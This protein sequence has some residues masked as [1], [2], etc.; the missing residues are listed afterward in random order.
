MASDGCIVLWGWE[1][2]GRK[3]GSRRKV[4]TIGLPKSNSRGEI[5]RM[6][7]ASTVFLSR[8]KSAVVAVFHSKLLTAVAVQSSPAL[9][10]P[11]NHR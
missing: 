6:R 4:L 9:F 3:E 11:L 1:R 2:D 5:S 7:L 10:K 8:H